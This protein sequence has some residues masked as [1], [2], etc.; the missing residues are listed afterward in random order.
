MNGTPGGAASLDIVFVGG[1]LA[2]LLAAYRLATQRPEC[3]FALFEKAPEV[4]GT[5]TW[6]FHETDVSAGAFDWLRPLVTH[7]WDYQSVAF[8]T[9]ERGFSAPYH[10]ITSDALAKH[11]AEV[12]AERIHRGMGARQVTPTSVTL[13][14]GETVEAACVID[15]RGADP[16]M[17]C[18]VAFQKFVG[19]TVSLSEP[20]GLAGPVIMDA[21]VPQTDGYRFVYLLPFSETD[22]LIEDTYYSN[23]PDFD[24][25]ALTAD[26]LDYASGKGYRVEQVTGSEKGVLPIVLA[27]KLSD[28]WPSEAARQ[29]RLGLRAG[30]FHPVTGYSLPNAVETADL[31]CRQNTFAAPAVNAKIRRYA[32]GVWFEGAYLRALNRMLFVGASGEERRRI[33]QRF[34]TLSEGL[35]ARFYA[36]RLNPYDKLRIVTGKP[37]IPILRG[38][39]CLPPSCADD[40]N[41]RHLEPH[42]DGE[43]T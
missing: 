33:F 13:E 21:C 7:S 4:G 19:L 12:L 30:L 35:I 24:K 8:P 27:G 17:T 25:D 5:H 23:T 11:M 37:P 29:P 14:N 1:G 26:I 28:I 6:S 20:H 15:G 22:V 10:S 34:Y 38:F 43:E 9:H 16:A 36:N 42:R 2:N 40:F 41:E 3:R 39:R 31:L 18:P 32:R